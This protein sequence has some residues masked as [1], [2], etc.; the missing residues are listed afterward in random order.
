MTVW[1]EGLPSSPLDL[2]FW[3]ADPR[4]NRDMRALQR[5]IGPIVGNDSNEIAVLVGLDIIGPVGVT[6]T[7]AGYVWMVGLP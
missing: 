5:L 3:H 6:D 4:A 2:L 7:A 1:P